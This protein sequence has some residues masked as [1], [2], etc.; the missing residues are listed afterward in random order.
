MTTL[1]IVFAVLAYLAFGIVV[2]VLTNNR[3]RE[4]QDH[5]I[6]VLFWPFAVVIMVGGGIAF[7]CLAAIG[8]AAMR[9]EE[10]IKRHKKGNNT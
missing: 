5:G 6:A 4:P 7:V 2:D 3:D 9:L 1:L 10:H 8:C